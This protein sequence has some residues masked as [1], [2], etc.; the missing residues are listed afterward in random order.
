MKTPRGTGQNWGTPVVS[1]NVTME[2]VSVGPKE[3]R[4]ALL[5]VSKVLPAGP[6]IAQ[7]CLF[8]ATAERCGVIRVR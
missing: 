6:T 1:T 8:R 3:R 5:K 2:A 4:T 7:V